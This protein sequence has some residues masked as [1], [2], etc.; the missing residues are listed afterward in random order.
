MSDVTNNPCAPAEGNLGSTPEWERRVIEKLATGAL[1]EQ[2]RARRWSVFFKF[3]MMAYLLLLLVLYLPWSKISGGL[4]EEH[5][6]LVEVNGVISADSE[7]SA[8]NVIT[9]LRAAFEDKNTRGVIM[10]IN[11]PGGSPVQA[12]YINDEMTR[13]RDEHPDI[14]LYAVITNV[15]ASGGY[16]VAV[17]ADEI[18]ADKSSLVGSIG[19]LSNGFGFVGTMDLLGVE[20]RLFTAGESKGFLDPFS[21]LKPKDVEHF[22]G[23]LAEMHQQFIEVVRAG[24]GGRLIADERLFSGLVWSGARSVELGL[25]DALGSSSY[26]AREIIGVENIVDFTPSRGFL[27]KLAERTGATMARTFWE[28]ASVMR[29]GLN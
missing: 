20:R 15:C 24:R 10:R 1:V 8:D 29:P 26:V 11:S 17:A 18:Y 21:P 25:V 27:E 13:L 5:S 4:D 7:A 3:A 14:P 22:Q 6:A 9:A 16:Y 23:V 19:V 12:G 2:R 28:Q